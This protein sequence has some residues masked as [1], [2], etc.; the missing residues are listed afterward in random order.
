MIH[1]RA[2]SLDSCFYLI[3]NL[4]TN[5]RLDLNV[6]L[7]FLSYSVDRFLK[8]LILTMNQASD[9]VYMVVVKECIE[10]RMTNVLPNIRC[11]NGRRRLNTPVNLTQFTFSW[12]YI[13]DKVLLD[14][15]DKIPINTG[16]RI[17][18]V[19]IFLLKEFVFA[20]IVPIFKVVDILT[21]SIVGL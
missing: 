18:N 15:P 12:F 6:F 13:I 17:L 3:R 5:L 10:Q 14:H 21:F 19:R 11:E 2:V 8:T 7:E 1:T 20:N 9:R 4:G 16:K